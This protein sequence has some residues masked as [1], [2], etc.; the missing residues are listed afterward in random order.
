MNEVYEFFKNN[1]NIA[2]SVTTVSRKLEIQRKKVY[3]YLAS[4]E[5]TD[6]Q[7]V[8]P[9]SVGSGKKQVNVFKF[10]M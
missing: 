5:N 3:H 7:R 8:D 10:I 4:D 6:I 2:Y 1:P 9:L